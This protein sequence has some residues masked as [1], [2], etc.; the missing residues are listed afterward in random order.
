[1]SWAK[2]D[3]RLHDSP[4]FNGLSDGALALWTRM[5]SR[6]AAHKTDGAVT[7]AD[8]DKINASRPKEDRQV[9][10]SALVD[11]LVT[12]GLLVPDGPNTWQDPSWIGRNFSAA[13]HDAKSRWD[14]LRSAQSHAKTR[15]DEALEKK[16][17]DEANEA[18]LEFWRIKDERLLGQHV[19]QHVAQRVSQSRPVPTAG[20]GTGVGTAAPARP[21]AGGRVPADVAALAELL[22]SDPEEISPCPRCGVLGD[23]VAEWLEVPRPPFYEELWTCPVCVAQIRLA[24]SG[25][26]GKERCAALT[27]PN[28]KKGQAGGEACSLPAQPRSWYC[29]YHQTE[30]SHGTNPSIGQRKLDQIRA[31]AQKKEAKP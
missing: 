10:W 6:M 17:A 22:G 11:E 15:G 26:E 31:E 28:A 30:R 14:D 7:E 24:R 5:Q 13:E 12:R 27:K 25:S 18:K 23:A 19:E 21:A 20:R 2:L 16:H 3:D 4:D 29:Q 1:M 9:P 8:F